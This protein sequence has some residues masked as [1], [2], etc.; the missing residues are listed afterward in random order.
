M[1][2][3]QQLEAALRSGRLAHCYLL[4][5]PRDR[6]EE[7]AYRA[8]RAHLCL[9]PGR[10]DPADP[11]GVCPSC[12]M[13]AG[14]IHPDLRLW[15]AE[16]GVWRIEQVRLLTAEAFHRPAVGDH[17]VHILADVH[18]LSVPSANALLKL[19]EE[20]PPG[21][22]FLLLA[23]EVSGLPPTFLS[24][25]QLLF[26]GP[27]E[28]HPAYEYGVD[29]HAPG[30]PAGVVTGSA[31]AAGAPTRK[32]QDGG[33]RGRQ[34]ETVE[35]VLQAVARGRGSG[36]LLLA[37]RLAEGD[38]EKM[39]ALLRQALR[40][41]VVELTREG[42]WGAARAALG[43]WEAVERAATRLE[44]HGNPRLVWECLL[45]ELA[46]PAEAGVLACPRPSRGL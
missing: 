46:G 37:K 33:D 26:S 45:L 21:T 18:L 39:C 12:R 2:P 40:D 30:A 17:R 8:A 20:P 24:R 1:T 10:P 27:P 38:G 43:A 16:R 7:V 4:C 9:E 15:E 6:L 32:A 19:L 35:E 22:L 3:R 5:G 13:A 44:A 34:E 25:C 29:V 42:Q 28:T 11:C 41:R 31:A 23:E 36:L 14:G